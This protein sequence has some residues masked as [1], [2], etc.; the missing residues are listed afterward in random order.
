MDSSNSILGTVVAALIAAVGGLWRE[1]NKRPT[2]RE[3]DDVKEENRKL[4]DKLDVFHAKTTEAVDEARDLAERRDAEN[5]QLRDE[6]ADLR[7]AVER[8]LAAG[9]DA[10]L[11]RP[12]TRRPAR[13]RRPGTDR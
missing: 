10:T 8:R 1:V 12:T 3:F 7:V 2:Q 11:A 4:Q 13:A 5:R 6:L 9:G